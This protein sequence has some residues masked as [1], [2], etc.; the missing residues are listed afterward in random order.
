[1]QNVVHLAQDDDVQMLA[2]DIAS[3]SVVTELAEVRWKAALSR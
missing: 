1:M 2:S 3:Y